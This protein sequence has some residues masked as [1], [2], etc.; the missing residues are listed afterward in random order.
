MSADGE[1][2]KRR[3]ADF[4]IS[5]VDPDWSREAPRAWWDPSRKLIRSIRRYQAAKAKGGL[6]G[7]LASKYWVASHRFWSVMAQADIPLNVRIG[8]GLILPHPNGVVVN[9]AATIG[10][11]CLIFQ[12]VSFAGKMTVGGHVDFGAG[13]KILGG[14]VIGDHAEIG[15]NAVVTRDVPPGGVVAGVPARLIR[16]KTIPGTDEPPPPDSPHNA[17][18]AS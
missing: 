3:E 2:P 16:V 6:F 12:Q 9:P 13:A 4:R 14:V 5:A 10:P 7:R 18:R 17:K 15:A 8:G 11:N 1:P